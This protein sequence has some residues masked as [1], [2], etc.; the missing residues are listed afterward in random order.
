MLFT[1]YLEILSQGKTVYDDENVNHIFTY[2][3]SQIRDMHNYLAK[4]DIEKHKD[5]LFNHIIKL[6]NYAKS[7]E[8]K[9]MFITLMYDYGFINSI[10]D[11]FS[12]MALYNDSLVVEFEDFI[13]GDYA[14]KLDG[15]HRDLLF[16]YIKLWVSGYNDFNKK[17]LRFMTK[18]L[19]WKR[20][21]TY[22]DGQ[23]K[24]F[25]VSLYMVNK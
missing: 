14:Q 19:N 10:D 20:L 7:L 25:L 6:F 16:E 5:I 3:K 2:S 13:V 22:S 12:S 24:G 4:I 8:L 11:I 1:K 23:L 15:K 21:V 18:E 17:Y 9:F